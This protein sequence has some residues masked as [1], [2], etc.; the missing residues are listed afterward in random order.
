LVSLV[1]PLAAWL[2]PLG[3]L[4]QGLRLL[5]RG[6]AGSNQ[7]WLVFLV[8]LAMILPVGRFAVKEQFTDGWVDLG[9]L[10]VTA[11]CEPKKH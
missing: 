4:I 1:G 5:G 6:S 2:V 3:A 8:G 9:S 11:S 10:E 7:S